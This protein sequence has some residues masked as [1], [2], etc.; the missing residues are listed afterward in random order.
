MLVRA[1]TGVSALS[2]WRVAEL[3][4]R[5]VYLHIFPS[6]KMISLRPRF[7]DEALADHQTLDTLDTD[8]TYEARKV[9]DSVT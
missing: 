2:S 8:M 6:V 9:A 7:G 3:K 1:T 5:L 4:R